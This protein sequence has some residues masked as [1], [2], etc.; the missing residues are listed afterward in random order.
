MYGT[1]RAFSRLAIASPFPQ[2]LRLIRRNPPSPCA[3]LILAARLDTPS[4]TGPPYN[5]PSRTS[6]S[7]P[8]RA[9]I[10]E[11]SAPR[12]LQSARHQTFDPLCS[13]QPRGL[14]SLL[15]ITLTEQRAHPAPPLASP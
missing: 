3:T 10:H 4:R 15:P 12:Q 2:M 6:H 1:R 9:P 11:T 13:P 7:G 14:F 8:P 5:P